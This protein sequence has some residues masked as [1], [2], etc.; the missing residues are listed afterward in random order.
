MNSGVKEISDRVKQ[1]GVEDSSGIFFADIPIA[2]I[3][4]I[5]RQKPRSEA[6]MS[7]E[8]LSRLVLATMNNANEDISGKKNLYGVAG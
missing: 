3:Y 7:K 1:D 2:R 6:R 8:P 5:M 4:E